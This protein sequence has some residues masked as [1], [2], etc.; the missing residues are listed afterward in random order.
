MALVAVPPRIPEHRRLRV[1]VRREGPPQNAWVL[2][3]RA[4]RRTQIMTPCTVARRPAA[5]DANSAIQFS[6]FLRGLERAARAA[7]C[8][9]SAVPAKAAGG[10]SSTNAALMEYTRPADRRR[11]LVS[12]SLGLGGGVA[13]LQKRGDRRRQGLGE[14]YDRATRLFRVCSGRSAA[15]R[16][17]SESGR[18]QGNRDTFL[19]DGARTSCALPRVKQQQADSLLSRPRPT[20]ARRL[21]SVN[22]EFAAASPQS[23]GGAPLW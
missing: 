6:S 7:A 22:P 12:L 3:I 4:A 20:G 15:F 14:Q 8:Q 2:A 18:R 5:L 11:S 1:P 9:A 13:P 17:R 16:Q 23:G 10:Q 19:F 21:L